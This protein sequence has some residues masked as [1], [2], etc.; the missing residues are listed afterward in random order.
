MKTQFSRRRNALLTPRTLLGGVAVLFVLVL[1]LVARLLPGFPAYVARPG[2]SLGASLA[3][4]THKLSAL[5][6]DTGGLL[7]RLDMLQ[8]ENQALQNE[9]RR[10][11]ERLGRLGAS[12]ASAPVLTF[13]AAVIARPPMS[14]YDTLVVSLPD[15]VAPE[16]GARVYASGGVPIG[17]LASVFKNTAQVALYS[18]PGE[19]TEGWVGEKRLPIS[20]VGESGGAFSAALPRDSAIVENDIVFIPG[21]GALPIGT[22]THVDTD[23][24]STDAVV[25]IAP[26][27]NIFSLTEVEIAK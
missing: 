13:T 19:T 8:A 21:P 26:Y 7:E 15:G 6:A 5:F 10:L 20:L 25:H 1:M 24:A 27:V 11:R 4:S 18:S 12:T 16:A 22:V 9:N 3:D 23:P 17:T 2:L 14:P